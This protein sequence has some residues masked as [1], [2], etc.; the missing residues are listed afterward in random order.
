MKQLTW[1][2]KNNLIEIDH[3]GNYI[4]ELAE[5]WE[6]KT[7]AK[8]WIFK[9]R[10]GVEFHNGKSF[11]ANDVIYTLNLHRGENSKSKVKVLL[12]GV[13]DLEALDS[14]TVMIKLKD[15]DVD[16]PGILT[17]IHLAI[18]C[19]GDDEFKYGTGGYMLEAFEPGVRSIAKRNPNYWKQGR[20]HF[21]SVELLAIPDANSRSNALV[22]G[23]INAYD[24]CDL[25]TIH[26]LKGKKNVNIIQATGKRFFSFPMNCEIAPYNDPDVRM[27]LKLAIDRENLLKAILKGY[28]AIGND[29]PINAVY[30]DYVPGVPQTPHDPGKAKYLLKKAGAQDHIFKLHAADAAFQGAIDT[31]ILMKEHAAKAGMKFEVVRVP[32]DGYWSNVWNKKPFS[33]SSWAGRATANMIFTSALYSKAKWN[34]SRWKNKRFDELL[35]RSRTELDRAKRRDMYFEMQ[36]L[37]NQDGGFLVPLFADFIDAVDKNVGFGDISGVYELDG[38]RASER[39]WFKS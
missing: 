20:A 21:D 12:S 32:N 34:A 29:F 28:G 26:L 33:A 7:G 3:K 8:E 1:Q 17:D 38:Q 37:I 2:L 15:G 16:F 23:Q 13:D 10:K 4:P 31:G 27:A 24:N 22:S 30:A 5:N 35:I 11:S 18:Q 36:T 9:L 6:A 14:H 19:E 39:W 25:K